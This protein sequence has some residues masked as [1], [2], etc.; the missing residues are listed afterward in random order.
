MLNAVAH[1]RRHLDASAKLLASLSYQG[2]LQRG[3]ALVRDR[4]GRS[5][6]TVA[7]VAAGQH[8]DIELADGHVE[9]E[10]IEVRKPAED[11]QTE[12]RARRGQP[13]RLKTGQGGGTQGSLF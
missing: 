3:F 11:R 8:L 2:V 9:A 10:A 5:V 4:E 12:P 13:M 6:R 7:R 1:H